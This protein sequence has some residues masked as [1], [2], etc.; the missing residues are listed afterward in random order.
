M[1]VGIH[2]SVNEVSGACSRQ[3]CCKGCPCNLNVIATVCPAACKPPS[4]Y[5]EVWTSAAC[6]AGVGTIQQSMLAFAVREYLLKSL[7]ASQRNFACFRLWSAP[8]PRMNR[9]DT[10]ASTFL[11]HSSTASSICTIYIPAFQHRPV[12]G[13]GCNGIGTTPK[14]IDFRRDPSFQDAKD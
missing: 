11:P 3:T 8:E 2:I 4:S 12:F 1:A 7:L 14:K 6:P 10:W 5:V 13:T 9:L